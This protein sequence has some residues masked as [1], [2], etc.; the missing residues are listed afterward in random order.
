[1]TSSR[2]TTKGRKLLRTTMA[3][4]FAGTL[5]ASPLAGA[6][7]ASTSG[8]VQIMGCGAYEGAI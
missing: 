6:S 5:L 2:T 7:A 8:D 3:A 4:V 1:M